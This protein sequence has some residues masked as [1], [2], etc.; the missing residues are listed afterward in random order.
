MNFVKIY[1]L[2]KYIELAISILFAIPSRDRN[3]Y[4]AAG[5][6]KVRALTREAG[7]EE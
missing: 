6:G 5:T 7:R 4:P 2:T 1:H 3:G